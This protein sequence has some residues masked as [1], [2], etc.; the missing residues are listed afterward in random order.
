MLVVQVVYED[1]SRT[2]KLVQR[3]RDRINAAG[4][5][6]LIEIRTLDLDT[7]DNC[8][9]SVPTGNCDSTHASSS[10]ADTPIPSQVLLSRF[11]GSASY[12]DN[13]ELQDLSQ[14]ILGSML[15]S[16]VVLN[17]L[18]VMQLEDS[19]PLQLA[20]L[21]SSRFRSTL[22]DKTQNVVK[23]PSTALVR[24]LTVAALD[25]AAAR[26]IDESDATMIVL[27][28]A[29]GGGSRGV[30]LVD[31][32]RLSQQATAKQQCVDECNQ[33]ISNRSR[34]WL[35]QRLVGASAD[36]QVRVEIIDSKLLY[37]VVIQKLKADPKS[38]SRLWRAAENLCLCEVDDTEVA[39][40]LH[41]TS[42]ALS[43]KLRE[44]GVV[45]SDTLAEAMIDYS[46]KAATHV[47]AA[48]LAMEFK[49]DDK[50]AH[51]IDMNLQ[52]NYNFAAEDKHELV[53]SA[54]RYLQMFAR[55]ASPDDL[56]RRTTELPLPTVPQLLQRVEPY[57]KLLIRG[58]TCT[59]A[60][61]QA[62][63]DQHDWRLIATTR[64][65]TEVIASFAAGRAWWA[66]TLIA[67]I[68][69]LFGRVTELV[70]S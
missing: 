52:S 58:S 59:L 49:L 23:L 56:D 39:L 6:N 37:A 38:R 45:E 18:S 61:L 66:R 63:A 67:H 25:K 9:L 65:G 60:E 33:S 29:Y 69:V 54:D 53:G 5:T 19:K 42:E 28:P 14:L 7:S 8:V 44:I 21:A 46:T 20:R 32:V 13:A 12:R 51:M 43:T 11:S 27:K 40:T 68:D 16:V 22:S 24:Q 35:V 15:Q 34:G 47:N 50:C 57:A 36:L 26:V 31:W 70:L 3:L 48:I 62:Q 17:G 55:Y 2:E 10:T 64:T 41:P 4:L 1:G 30:H